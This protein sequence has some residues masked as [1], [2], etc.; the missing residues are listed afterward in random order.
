[1]TDD[2]SR[3]TDTICR[4]TSVQSA[5][6]RFDN[7][8]P[9]QMRPRLNPSS[10]EDSFSSPRRQSYRSPDSIDPNTVYANLITSQRSSDPVVAFPKRSPS[11]SVS[12]PTPAPRAKVAES[13]EEDVYPME[14]DQFL[15][16]SKQEATDEYS[17]PPS[18]LYTYQGNFMRTGLPNNIGAGMRGLGASFEEE[19]PVPMTSHFK[20]HRSPKEV[21]AD[22]PPPVPQSSLNHFAQQNSVSQFFL[23]R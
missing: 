4:N 19:E 13:Q 16:S 9:M 3:Y 6:E 10:P 21:P 7:K 22:A 2:A 23:L 12:Q 8:A 1:M 18:E 17:P 20:V 15:L 14:K 11:T 5:I